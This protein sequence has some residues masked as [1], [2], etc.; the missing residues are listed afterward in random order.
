MARP[1]SVSLQNL[2]M[3]HGQTEQFSYCASK[4]FAVKATKSGT[5]QFIAPI[6]ALAVQNIPQGQGMAPLSEV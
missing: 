1:M 3:L 4:P 6:C 2:K 5:V